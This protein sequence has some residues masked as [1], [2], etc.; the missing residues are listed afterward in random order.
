MR[1]ISVIGG[2]LSLLS[3]LSLHLYTDIHHLFDMS[4]LFSHAGFALLF[5]A[6]PGLMMMTFPVLDR[7]RKR[8]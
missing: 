1:R 5:R 4:V 2:R 8:G 7:G 3:Q 6:C